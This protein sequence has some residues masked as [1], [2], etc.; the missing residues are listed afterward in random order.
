MVERVILSGAQRAK[1]ERE[2]RAAL[3]RECCG[4]IE[5]RVDGDALHVIALHATRN[6]AEREDRFEIDPKEQFALLRRLRGTE[7][8]IVGC[9]HSHPNGR[10]DASAQDHV[11][12]GEVGYVWLILALVGGQSVLAAFVC[13]GDHLRRI[14]LDATAA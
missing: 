3:P 10:Q 1:I 9:Y 2:A 5:G 8:G 13:E 7:T 4:L 12:G 6:V 14:A 11:G